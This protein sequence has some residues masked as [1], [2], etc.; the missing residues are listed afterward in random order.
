MPKTQFATSTENSSWVL[1]EPAFWTRSE[2]KKTNHLASI[3][4]EF[5]KESSGRRNFESYDRG[6]RGGY[7]PRRRPPGFRVIVDNVHRDTSWQV[8]TSADMDSRP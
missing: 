3:V 1:R 5:A 7:A 2:G 6:D 8:S 4:V